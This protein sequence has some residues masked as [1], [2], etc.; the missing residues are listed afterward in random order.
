M[1]SETA[2]VL[3]KSIEEM[4]KQAMFASLNDDARNKLIKDALAS[5]FSKPD[6]G[7]GTSAV[8]RSFNDAVGVIAREVVRDSVISNPEIRAAVSTLVE[9]T[10][11]KI[12]QHDTIIEFV[13]ELLTKAVFKVKENY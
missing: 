1:A 13:E 11:V 10:V 4:V 7:R 5:L 9:K 6:Y 12:L 3:E 2:Q 8:E